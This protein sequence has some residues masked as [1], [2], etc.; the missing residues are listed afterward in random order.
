MVPQHA[1][2]WRDPKVNV[3]DTRTETHFISLCFVLRAKFNMGFFLYGLVIA[4]I[5]ADSVPMN[6]TMFGEYH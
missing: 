6:T 2:P 3:H 1:T 4:S 5:L